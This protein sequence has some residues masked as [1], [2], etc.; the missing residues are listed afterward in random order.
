[1]SAGLGREDLMQSCYYS[2]QGWWSYELCPGRH[3][4]QFHVDEGAARPDPVV[5]LGYFDSQARHLL[6]SL[7]AH[8][9]LHRFWKRQSWQYPV[10][11]NVSLVLTLCLIEVALTVNHRHFLMQSE[12]GLEQGCCMTKTHLLMPGRSHG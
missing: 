8:Y 12:K 2:P 6:Y 3:L 11:G 1:M 5:S 7:D 10:V 4:R 9:I